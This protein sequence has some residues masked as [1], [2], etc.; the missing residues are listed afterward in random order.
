MAATNT[1]KNKHTMASEMKAAS[2][3]LSEIS[4]AA[5]MTAFTWAMID[6]VNARCKPIMAIP[7]TSEKMILIK[8]LFSPAYIF[9]Q[10]KVMML[11]TLTHAA[12]SNAT[13]AETGTM[14]MLV[15]LKEMV[16]K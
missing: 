14:E 5:G 1:S 11:S 4:L 3:L 2:I 12:S 7:V 16:H 10:D 13:N 9:I 15:A 6:A 8:N